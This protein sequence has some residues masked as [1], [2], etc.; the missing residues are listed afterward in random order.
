[1]NKYETQAE[2]VIVGA[3]L[4]GLRAAQI[5][6]RHG[7]DVKLLE[8]RSRVG[9]RILTVTTD[10]GR[11]T[12]DLGPSW[13]WAEHN[14]VQQ[15]ARALDIG[16]FVQPETGDAVF[17]RGPE[18]PSQRFTP[19]WHQPPAYRFVGG[20]AALSRRLLEQLPAGC[21][22]LETRV[23]RISLVDG[24]LEILAE[25]KQSPLKYLAQHA[26][27]ALP[28]RLAAN[29]LTFAPALPPAVIDEMRHTQTW[30]G[31]AMKAM[32]V[33]PTPFWRAAGLSGLGV[34]HP[35]PVQQ[36]HDATPADQTVGALFGW[37]GN[38]SP[39][40]WLS[41]AQRREA[42]IAQAVRM[43]GPEA[44]QPI[45]YTDYNWAHDPL[46]TPTGQGLLPEE[47]NP[48]YGHPL[49]L[50]P[51]LAGRLH[52][53]GTEVS[54]LGGGYME[55]ALHIADQVARQVLHHL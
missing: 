26:I 40:R 9:G 47:E 16:M 4:S 15:L 19:E 24:C 5:L 37:I 52:W 50:K 2:V 46:T 38:D 29:T 11:G 7:I 28:P 22:S 12:F 21:L 6:T 10:D 20:T 1:M 48:R 45:Y 25:T 41:T 13:I 30:M 54:P 17:D 35:G 36:F 55:G 31:Q 14:Q 32:L 23:H 44:S 33:Y 51:Q 34:S 3:G 43:F 42:I 18:F 8:A 27:V 53:A 39:G 49:L